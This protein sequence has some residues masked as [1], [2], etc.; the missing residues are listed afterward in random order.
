MADGVH[1]GSRH[2]S[3]EPRAGEARS[4]NVESARLDNNYAPQQ[5]AAEAPLTD[6]QCVAILVAIGDAVG[7]DS[8]SFHPANSGE[9]GT[10]IY[11]DEIPTG[12]LSTNGGR[13]QQI[14]SNSDHSHAIETVGVDN[15]PLTV[16]VPPG[17]AP[18]GI[19]VLHEVWGMTAP[20]AAL[21]AR[22]ADSGKIAAAPHLYHR[23]GDPVVTDGIFTKGRRC[24]D[25]FTV[26]RLF[27]RVAGHASHV[28][29]IGRQSCRRDV[30]Q[31]VLPALFGAIC[32]FAD[33]RN[34]HPA[35][36][37][38]ISEG[39]IA[40]LDGV[41][42]G[43]HRFDGEIK[44]DNLVVRVFCS[45]RHGALYGRVARIWQDSGYHDHLSRIWRVSDGAPLRLVA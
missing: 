36:P 3:I 27:V 33:Q 14:R 25:T 5:R 20:I 40:T 28:W 6:Y 9:P 44:H 32:S 11:G 10:E 23:T 22:L 31:E 34:E 35:G 12:R 1:A 2:V 39:V 19:V 13:M 7:Q 15:V 17:I 21:A 16:P 42:I 24:H 18:A 38:D 43:F 30:Q 29:T 26:D 37:L 4:K 8:S 45:Q 41:Q